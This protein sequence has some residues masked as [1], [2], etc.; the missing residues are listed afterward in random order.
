MLAIGIRYLCGRAVATHPAD[1]ESVEWPPHPDRAFMAMVAAHYETEGNQAERDALLWLESQ[2]PPALATSLARKRDT[3]T[4]FVPVN[5][6]TMPKMSK[7]KAPSVDQV[8]TGIAL[9]P[10]NRGK[11]PRVFPSA[12]PDD[13]VVHMIWTAEP[14]VRLKASLEAICAKV[15]SLGHSSSLVQM[16]IDENPPQP[17]LVPANGHTDQRLRITGSGRLADLD[18][19]FKAGLRPTS[20]L[21]QG[22]KRPS[23]QPL[24]QRLACSVF[25]NELVV[26]RRLEGR[27]LGLEATARFMGAL[28]DMVMQS[29]PQPPPEWISGHKPDGARSEQPH[30]AFMPLP[31]VGA[32]HADGHLLGVALAIPRGL[33]P[34]EAARCLAAVLG[35]DSSTEPPTVRV[36]DGEIFDWILQ[37]D[38]R[39]DRPL[40]LQAD[41]W[42]AAASTWGTVTPIVFDRHPKGKNMWAQAEDTVA[43]ACE[44]VGLPPPRQVILAPTSVFP[45]SPHS[46]EFPSLKRKSDGGNLHHTH[47]III[48]DEPVQGPVLV[49]AGRYRGYGLCRPLRSG[50]GDSR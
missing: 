24:E 10:E 31:Y 41:T 49:G 4:V 2:D 39:S 43:Q 7:G 14:P 3:V 27:P 50:G 26:L 22:Y 12:V 40:A 38:L 21:W 36:Y 48:F 23:V 13:P 34:A 46:R 29:C 32:E 37:P 6:T 19:R 30:L 33:E 42:T 16:W 28:R 8:K 35:D 11:Q 18:Y 45:G 1:R 5:D 17:N 25:N 47:A 44:R 20:S 15:T 9:L